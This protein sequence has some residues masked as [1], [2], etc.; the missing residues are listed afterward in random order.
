MIK[1]LLRPNTQTTYASIALLALRLIA[2]P[3]MII[4]GWGKI[5]MP[6]GWLPEGANINIS[7]IFQ[8]LAALSEF[9]GGVA[10]IL[11]ILTPIASFGMSITMLV[12]ASVHMFIFKDPFVNLSGGLS[13]EPAMGYFAMALVLMFV[14]PGKFSLDKLFFGEK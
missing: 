2:G 3:A 4:H 11:G 13:Y 7:P 10:W 9:G 14:G 5:Q 1:Q 6:L 12:A 8:L